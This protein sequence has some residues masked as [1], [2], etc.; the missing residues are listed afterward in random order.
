M[1]SVGRAARPRRDLHHAPARR[2]L[3][4][5]AGHAQDVRAAPARHAADR[6]RPA[7]PARPLQLAGARVRQAH[8][9]RSRSTSCARETE[10]ERDELPHPRLP[11]RPRRHR[12]RLRARRG[13]AAR[14]LRR[15]DRPRRSASRPAPSAARCSAARRSRS[16]TAASSPPDAVVGAPRPGRRIVI[17]GDTAPTETVRVLAEGADV[18]VHE[19]TFADEDA[20]RAAE[21]MHST[22]RQAAEVARRRRRAAARAH[23]RLAAILRQRAAA[24][25][26]RGLPGHR[27]AEGLRHDRG[28]VRRARRAAAREGRSAS[29]P[30]RPR[31]SVPCVCPTPL[32]RSREAGKESSCRSMPCRP[33]PGSSWTRKRSAEPSRG[34]RTR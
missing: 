8:A 26:A 2:P 15:R 25:G 11:G 24:R 1:R 10:L 12:G 28:A 6:L 22:A 4:R 32:T 9:T 27:P 5:P 16:P 33:R 31:A 3:P 13:R 7:R 19:A 17:P 21:T 34:S 20:D 18:L 14:P 23:A 29:G 30:G